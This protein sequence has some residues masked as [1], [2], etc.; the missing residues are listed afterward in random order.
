MALL[1]AA[2]SVAPPDTTFVSVGHGHS[3][4]FG[5]TCAAFRRGALLYD[6]AMKRAKELVGKVTFGAIFAMFG[7]SEHRLTAREQ[8]ALSDCLDGV[9]RDMRADLNAPELPLLVG[10]YEAGISRADIHPT[11][12]FGKL[13]I[14]QLQMVPGKTPRSAI[15]PT[16][17]LPMQDT[18]HF[19]MAGHKGW[20]E[21]AIGILVE[22]GWAPWAR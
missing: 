4:S 10:D 6:V 8:R 17:G 22:R 7:Q 5:G 9:A 21:R 2:M 1:R 13:I 18:H 11:S 16:D 12:E 20:A 14:A 3:G 19:N 15:I